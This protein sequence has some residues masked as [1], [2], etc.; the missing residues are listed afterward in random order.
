MNPLFLLIMAIA[1]IVYFL[2]NFYIIKLTNKALAFYPKTNQWLKSTI[3]LLATLFPLSRISARIGFN[4]ILVQLINSFG[5]IY[6]AYFIYILLF[7]GIMLF[8]KLSARFLKFIPPKIKEPGQTGQITI[9]ITIFTLSSLI[10]L[11]GY[12]NNN[13]PQIE[14]IKI[15]I[16]GK[17][18][19][20]NKIKIVGIAD[21]HL[22]FFTKTSKIKK[23]VSLINTEK[24]DLIF[25]A[26][27]VVDEFFSPESRTAFINCLRK[28]SAKMGVYAVTGNHEFMYDEKKTMSFFSNAN[29]TLVRDRTIKIA[30]SFYLIGREDKIVNHWKDGNRKNLSTLVKDIDKSYPIFL[31]DHQPFGLKEAVTNGIDFQFSGHTHNGQLFPG[32]IL[33]D[34]LY[35]QSWGYLK[36]GNTHFY[37]TCGVGTWGPPIKT[38]GI[39]EIVVIDVELR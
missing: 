39:S 19:S 27:D 6:L 8:L 4:P 38:T 24:P 29:I 12:I 22:D 25:L 17:K 30:D 3:I 7:I 9:L 20:T 2:A 26:G 23:I 35:E 37:I 21:L 34:L 1:L 5:L 11:L 28:L 13:S 14:R 10:L 18:H 31:M 32:N 36:K 15:T 16:S 33:V